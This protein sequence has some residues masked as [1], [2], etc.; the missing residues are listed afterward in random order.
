MQAST[1]VIEA[2]LKLK[3]KARVHHF[4][5]RPT[6]QLCEM[7]VSKKSV[8]AESSYVAALPADFPQ[9]APQLLITVVN[10]T[11]RQRC[12]STVSI[13]MDRWRHSAGT[14]DH[15]EAVLWPTTAGGL[16][17]ESRCSDGTETV[18]VVAD[19]RIEFVNSAIDIVLA[20]LST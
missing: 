1:I 5:K 20:R 2:A 6:V 18:V 10:G 3:W 8:A 19:F 17:D 14:E 12:G 9:R 7:N 16:A 11:E 4:L 15:A 13:S